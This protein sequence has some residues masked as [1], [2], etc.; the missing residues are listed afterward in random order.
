MVTM[1]KTRPTAGLPPGPALPMPV[2]TVLFATY[3]HVFYPHWQRRYGDM[4]TVRL[5]GRN[6]VVLA[7]PELIREV[8]NGPP[9]VFHAGEGNEILRPVMGD[10]SLLLLDE[11]EH[12]RARKLLMPAFAGAALRGYRDMFT[13]IA[14]EGVAGWPIATPTKCIRH[15]QHITL[16][17]ILR[18]VFGVTE[19]RTLRKIRPL[20]RRVVGANSLIMLG[21]LYPALRRLPPWRTFVQQ[22]L[23]L[24]ALLYQ[25]I[26]DRRNAH[27]LHQRRD[28][29]SRL[30]CAGGSDEGLTDQELRDQLITLLLAGHETTST[31][32]A[33]TV[34][35]L[36]RDPRAMRA[37]VAAADGDDNDYLEAVVKEAMRVHPVVPAVARRL[38]EPVRIGDHLL[39]AGTVVTPSIQLVQQSAEQ[40]SEPLTYRPE[41]FAEGTVSTANWLPFG[42]G[43]RRCIGASFS[44]SESVA[45][46][47]V[48][49]RRFTLTSPTNRP[50]AVRP[51]NI[52][53]IP[54]RGATVIATSRSR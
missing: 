15:F 33:W 40:H 10:H 31:A 21:G 53:L 6:A 1:S 20:L 54:A 9:S 29:L 4:F 11:E 32:L 3:R 28:V 8:F 42:G 16:E 2:Q 26:R 35:E 5:P 24:D 23:Q 50:E 47:R 49:L 18:V 30:L 44:L 43:V 46:L 39:P 13:E 25:E 22:T 36:V 48:V 51:R 27:G 7:D 38:T 14:T 19:Q 12:R 52:T 37:A 17:V 34:H 45:I 41:R